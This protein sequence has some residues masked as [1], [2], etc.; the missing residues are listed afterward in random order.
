MN[1]QEYLFSL[2]NWL[3]PA[4]SSRGPMETPTNSVWPL[5]FWYSFSSSGISARHGGHHVPQKFTSTGL[6]RKAESLRGWLVF[7]SF[8][9]KSGAS[10]PTLG[11]SPTWE[12][13]VLTEY[14]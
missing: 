13:P 5:N 9:W 7:T 10:E 4:G 14:T 8:N 12:A 1:V 11:A 6:P 2:T 3:T